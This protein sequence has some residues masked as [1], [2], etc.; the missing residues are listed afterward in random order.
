MTF[1]AEELRYL[2]GQR[3][4]RLATLAADGTLQNNPVGF[5]VHEAEGYIEI[6]GYDMGKS[7]KFL[8]IQKNPEVSLVI[9]D[10]ASLDP[11]EVRGIE[12]RGR[13][14][15][16]TGIERGPSESY[17]SAEA[18][19]IHPRRIRSWNLEGSSS[20]RWLP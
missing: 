14:E 10:I 4:G 20:A 18:I 11:W 8:N 13:A 12:I 15:P 2:A 9:D 5:T 19:R 17:L 7:R 3:L 16:V 1:T 6:G